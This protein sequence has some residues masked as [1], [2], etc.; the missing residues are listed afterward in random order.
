MFRW[1]TTQRY[2]GRTLCFAVHV[3]PDQ[4]SN[5]WINACVS[6]LSSLNFP[7]YKSISLSLC[8]L[9]LLSLIER[10]SLF[11]GR[12]LKDSC[13]L[14]SAFTTHWIWMRIASPLQTCLFSLC[15]Y[16]DVLRIKMSRRTQRMCVPLRKTLGLCLTLA[17]H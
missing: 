10:L 4:Q 12:A 7:R 3:D 13:S 17:A 8:L 11:S 6:P 9:K 5:D 1:K 16:K 14:M 2:R 15:M